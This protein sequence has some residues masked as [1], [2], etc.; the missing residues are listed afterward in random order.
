MKKI[1]DGIFVLLVADALSMKLFG[2]FSLIQIDAGKAMMLILAVYFIAKE[3]M[4]DIKL[5]KEGW[6][7]MEC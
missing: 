7:S 2:V 1:I 3:I 4:H 5:E 6:T